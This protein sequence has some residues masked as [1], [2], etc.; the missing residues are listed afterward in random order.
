MPVE[1]VDLYAG[2]GGM[3]LGFK[4]AG[5]RILMAVEANESAAATYR[6]NHRRPKVLVERI[7]ASWNIVDKLKTNVP[8]AK[9]SLLIG[10][11]PCQGWSSLGGRGSKEQRLLL[12][13]SIDHF[14]IQ[15]RLL[16]PP[17]VVLE[18]VR[19]LATRDGGAHLRHVEACLRRSGY[20]V[21]SLDLRAA[22]Y[23]VP[24]LRHRVFV[25]GI[26][27]D[28]GF[29][30]EIEPSHDKDSWLTVW[31]A[32]SDL[33]A[34]RAG[35][36]R[37]RYNKANTDYQ[38][39]LRGDCSELTWHQ[40][41]D[42]S[43][44]IL[45]VLNG[46]NGAGASRADLP[47]T[48]KLTSGFHNTYCRLWADQPAP[49]VTSSAGRIS[50]GRNAHP[51]NDRALTPREAARLQSFP[52]SYKW[53]GRRW[54]VYQQIGNAVPPMLAEALARPLIRSLEAVL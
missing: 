24:Q 53:L 39:R 22:D 34:L 33:P 7:D 9:C 28:M 52:D 10:G 32:I 8:E 36:V 48:V 20:R 25:V 13:A 12:N 42:H 5:G 37:S 38:K 40:A 49:A 45:E 26:R 44:D 1:I 18:N 43:P 31:E 50:S 19:G 2:A 14:L 16:K 29:R 17:A 30:F 21:T 51:Y 46:L 54:A 6:A 35:R 3:S 23:G 4:N 27:S 15:T 47:K 41:P 11:P